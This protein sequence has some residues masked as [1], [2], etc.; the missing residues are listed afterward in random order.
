MKVPRKERKVKRQEHKE[1]H[2]SLIGDRA[3]TLSR[4]GGEKKTERLKARGKVGGKVQK[5]AQK[6]NRFES[7]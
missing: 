6:V 3:T 7:R 4:G 5:E 1:K 2:D